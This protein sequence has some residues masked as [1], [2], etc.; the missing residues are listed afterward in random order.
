MKVIEAPSNRYKLLTVIPFIILFFDFTIGE[1]E[2][3]TYIILVQVTLLSSILFFALFRK[4]LLINK[5]VKWLIALILFL[6]LTIPFSSDKVLTSNMFLKFVLSSFFY[7]YA[8]NYIN[9]EEKFL[10]FL[11]FLIFA[12]L[13]NYGYFLYSS[14]YSLGTTAY[15]NQI[16]YIGH[17]AYASQF[18]FPIV[19]ISFFSFFSFFKKKDRTYGYL[20]TI[21]TLLVMILSFRRTNFIILVVGLIILSLKL[22]NFRSAMYK[23]IPIILIFLF[24]GWDFVE[25]TVLENLESRARITRLDNYTKEGRVVENIGVFNTISESAITFLF[26]TGEL[27]NSAGKYGLYT[28]DKWT[29][30]REIH[31]DYGNLLFG[32]GIIAL[33]LYLGFIF[34]M[35]KFTHFE[36]INNPDFY[37]TLQ[38]Y[39]L[40]LIVILFVNGFSSGLTDIFYRSTLSILLGGS[41]R[42]LFSYKKSLKF[43]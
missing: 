17:Q 16:M 35:Y 30:I 12:C 6:L 7:I 3:R 39:V 25:G 13:L 19:V 15:R 21:L 32:G 26:G 24:I 29:Y 40:F 28:G 43:K 4:R 38:N 22:R 42:I 5:P 18:V 8:F 41:S 14:I 33:L 34:S 9:N 20:F 11:K 23:I 37:R 36:K 2:D 27:W 1:F 31:N 10:R